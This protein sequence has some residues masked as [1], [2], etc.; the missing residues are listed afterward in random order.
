MPSLLCSLVVFVAAGLLFEAGAPN[1]SKN[2]PHVPF[3]I[4]RI[5]F[6]SW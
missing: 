3:P 4:S 6:E 2:R 1:G 5:W